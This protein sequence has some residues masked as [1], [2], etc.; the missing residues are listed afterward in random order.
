MRTVTVE[1][2]FVKHVITEVAVLS[3]DQGD[4]VVFVDPHQQELAEDD[5]AYGCMVCGEPL[6][7]NMNTECEG[8]QQ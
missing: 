5:A 7:G 6:A 2:R 3:N 8:Y 1:H 4:P